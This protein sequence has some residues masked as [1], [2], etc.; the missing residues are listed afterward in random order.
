MG[1]DNEILAFLPIYPKTNGFTDVIPKKNY[2]SYAFSQKD[3]V[4]VNLL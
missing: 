3:D 1:G 4:L 2:T